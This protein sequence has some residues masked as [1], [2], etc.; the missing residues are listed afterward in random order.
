M[1]GDGKTEQAGPK[2]GIRSTEFWI[3]SV[4]GV[5]GAILAFLPVAVEGEPTMLEIA[6]QI[7]G[8]IMSTGAALGYAGSRGLAKLGS[9]AKLLLMAIMLPFL[10]MA[11]SPKGYI[12]AEGISELV[13]GIN[14]R[15]D[16]LIERLRGVEAKDLPDLNDDEDEADVPDDLDTYKRSSKILQRIVDAAVADGRGKD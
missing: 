1:E 9:K 11:C 16:L 13:D 14:Y 2:P 15:H 7:G 10:L 5:V 4:L 8:M 3:C 12:R 6:R